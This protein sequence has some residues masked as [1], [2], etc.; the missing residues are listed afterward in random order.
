MEELKKEEWVY[1]SGPT[2]AKDIYRTYEEEYLAETEM[3]T[4][5]ILDETPNNTMRIVDDLEELVSINC[6][7]GEITYGEHYTPDRAAEIFW[8]SL[9]DLNPLREEVINLKKQIEL[10]EDAIVIYNE[11]RPPTLAKK[12]MLER[13]LGV[14]ED[15]VNFD[16]A[17][18]VID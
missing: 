8:T 18:K 11:Q 14:K 5:K 2:L 6:I 4:L 15:H 16:N 10:L 13:Y 7:T 1:D 9:A 3:P 17:M 12:F